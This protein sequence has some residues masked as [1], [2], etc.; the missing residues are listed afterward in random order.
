MTQSTREITQGNTCDRRSSKMI[1]GVIDP[2]CFFTFNPVSA[3]FDAIATYNHFYWIPEKHNIKSTEILEVTTRIVSIRTSK[4]LTLHNSGTRLTCSRSSDDWP[5][6]PRVNCLYALQIGAQCQ[7][8]SFPSF[9][10]PSRLA[11]EES[12]ATAFSRSRLLL[13]LPFTRVR[14]NKTKRG[15][16]IPHRGTVN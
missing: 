13:F 7:R 15:M 12:A 11:V 6:R 4:R 2:R 10:R 3:R 1:H 5:R 14:L 9:P 8:P 16:Q